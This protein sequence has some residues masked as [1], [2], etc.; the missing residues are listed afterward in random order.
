[1]GFHEG[2]HVACGQHQSSTY[3]Y[4]STPTTPKQRGFI[5]A[6]MLSFTPLTRH[7][8]IKPVASRFSQRIIFFDA[9]HTN[10]IFSVFVAVVTWM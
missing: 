4:K 1:M 7:L 9:F 10:S 8:K 5:P 3:H 2:I 6:N